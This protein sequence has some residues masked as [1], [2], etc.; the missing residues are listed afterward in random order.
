[1]HFTGIRPGEKL[2]EILVSEEELP[3]TE[4]RER[5]LVIL[6][7]LPE[8]RTETRSDGPLPFSGEYSSGDNNLE[9]DGVVELLAQH[10]LTVGSAPHTREIYA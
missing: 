1:V 5:N 3:R 2:H 8:L 6:P 7:I 9:Y 4:L 10:G